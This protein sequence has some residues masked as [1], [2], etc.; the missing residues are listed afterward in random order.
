MNNLVEM[1]VTPLLMRLPCYFSS[2]FC[3]DRFFCIFA[4]Q[5]KTVVIINHE[6]KKIKEVK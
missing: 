6:S 5:F 1:C 2:F 3:I 4:S